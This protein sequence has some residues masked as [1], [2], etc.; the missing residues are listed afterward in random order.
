MKNSS[1][2]LGCLLIILTQICCQENETPEEPTPAPEKL[3]SNYIDSLPVDE[4]EHFCQERRYV[5]IFFHSLNCKTFTCKKQ[6]KKYIKLAKR[7]RKREIIFVRVGIANLKKFNQEHKWK[8]KQL[9]QFMMSSFGWKK[10]FSDVNMRH[11]GIW[12]REIFDSVPMF[13]ESLDEIDEIDRHYFIY[14]NKEELNEEDFEVI[15]LSKLAHPLTIYYGIPPDSTDEA[16]QKMI[17]QAGT[18]EVFSYRGSDSKL[19]PLRT[20]QDLYENASRFKSLEFP[21]NCKLSRESMVY[22]THYKLP[23][24]IY[25]A[26][27]PEKQPFYKIYKKVAKKFRKYLMFC[28][29]DYRKMRGASN[30]DLKF[31]AGILAGGIPKEKP[32]MVRIVTYDDSIIRYKNFA[33]S[34]FNSTRLFVKNFLEG[35]LKPFTA[36]QN[37]GS[38]NF[39]IRKDGIR[40]IN[41]TKF[42]DLTTH[43]MDTHLVYVYSSMTKDFQKHLDTLKKLQFALG[44]NKRFKINILNHDKN[45]LDGNVHEDL[46]YVFVSNFNLHRKLYEG[47]IK[48]KEIFTFLAETL[49]WLNM[50]PEFVKDLVR[51]KQK[52]IFEQEKLEGEL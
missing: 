5:V 6:R 15:L 32:G 24:F 2:Y 8:L 31:Y 23:T 50:N 41:H 39:R 52:S 37:L 10:M 9:P 19:F 13:I 1:V 18:N 45:D 26:E 35:T 40:R 47:P 34:D 20:E 42:N 29:F 14:Y 51:R 21:S 22:I 7:N 28:T 17:K 3:P 36:D 11:L 33:D 48:F 4:L 16:F 38:K 43:K 49:P 30:N 27:Q 12:V 44:T 25:F 46:P